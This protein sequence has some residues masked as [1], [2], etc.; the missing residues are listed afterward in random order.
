MYFY[1]T[2]AENETEIGEIS[3]LFRAPVLPKI[4]FVGLGDEPTLQ[5]F[6]EILVKALDNLFVVEFCEQV[7]IF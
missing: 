4:V 3:D 1:E 2:N 6:K 5:L 7:N